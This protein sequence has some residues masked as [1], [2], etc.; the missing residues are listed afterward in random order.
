MGTFPKGTPW[1]RSRVGCVNNDYYLK[2]ALDKDLHKEYI[3]YFMKEAG[4]VL[5]EKNMRVT[6]Q[7]LCVYKALRQSNEHLTAEQIYQ[8]V[9]N[10]FPATSFAT[11]YTILQ[12]FKDKGLAREIRIEFDKSRFEDRID[13]HHHF[14]C[15]ECKKIFDVDIPLCPALEKREVDGNLIQDLQGYFYGICKECRSKR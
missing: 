14:Q 15:T 7:R 12:I 5:K 4:Q 10:Q 6:P 1:R 9:K 8:I 11:V 3:L 2:I 13:E